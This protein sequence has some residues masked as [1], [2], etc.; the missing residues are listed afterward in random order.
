[1]KTYCAGSSVG[2]FV[3]QHPAYLA[4]PARLSSSPVAVYDPGLIG[5]TLQRPGA[6]SLV[7]VR[8]GLLRPDGNPWNLFGSAG[9]RRVAAVLASL[10]LTFRNAY[11]G[12]TQT[13]SRIEEQ[14]SES[15]RR[16]G[17]ASS[18]CGY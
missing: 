13:I 4:R 17:P 14:V 10:V 11:R 5:T 7:E 18:W 9:E 16:F 15:P 2:A 8:D 6:S 12:I 3:V 1:M